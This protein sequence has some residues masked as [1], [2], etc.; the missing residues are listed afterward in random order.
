MLLRLAIAL[1]LGAAINV[2]VA[3]GCAIPLQQGLSWP[4]PM[5][6]SVIGVSPSS[7]DAQWLQSMGAWK[8][9][10]TNHLLFMGRGSRLLKIGLLRH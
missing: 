6:G 3:M 1:G 5:N 2:A 4:L 7:A 8:P 10:S 9:R